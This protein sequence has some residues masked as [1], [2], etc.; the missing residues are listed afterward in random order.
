MEPKPFPAFLFL[1]SERNVKLTKGMVVREGSKYYLYAEDTD[2]V[3][4]KVDVLDVSGGTTT[5]TKTDAAVNSLE[6]LAE[7]LGEGYTI[8]VNYMF[9]LSED[10]LNEIPTGVMYVTAV[11]AP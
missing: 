2:G 8:T 5:E 7:L 11:K 1:Q 6:R 9:S 4:L 3:E 10:K